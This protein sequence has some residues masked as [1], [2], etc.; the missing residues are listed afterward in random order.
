MLE[1]DQNKKLLG[2]FDLF[3]RKVNSLQENQFYFNLFDNGEVSK[4]YKIK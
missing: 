3:G 1:E 2:V 4:Q